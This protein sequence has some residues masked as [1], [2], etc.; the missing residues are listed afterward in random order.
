MNDTESIRDIRRRAC[1]ERYDHGK[2]RRKAV[3][4]ETLA[5]YLPPRRDP[6]ALLDESNKG[7]LASLIPIRYERMS[8]SDF[9]F[10]RGAA[11]VMAHDLAAQTTPGLTVQ[12]SGDCH[13]MNFGAFASPEGN[14]L[15]DIN[16]F[17][18]TLPDVDFTVDLRRLST[19]FAVAARAASYSEKNCRRIAEAVATAYRRHMA[20][21]SGLSPLEA[22]N[23]RIYM[24]RET[25]G[26]FDGRLAEKLRAAIAKTNPDH[27]E[28]ENF[29]H[30]E[31]K[32]GAWRILDRP[33][34][35]Y[36]VEDS[37]DPAARLDIAGVFGA[38][39]ST[40]PPEVLA[41]LQR[42][43]LRD[44][45]FKVVGVG[46]VGTYC[47]I[48][49][50]VTEDGDPLYLQLKEARASALERLGRPNWSGMQ[51]ARV[52]A[53]Q[54]VLQGAS[55]LFLGWTHDAASGRH[56]YVRHLKNR[57]L[58]SITEL[59]EEEALPQYAKLCGHTLARAH[60]RSADP[61]VLSGYMGKSGA[62]DDAIASFAMLYADQN[63]ADFESFVDRAATP[64]P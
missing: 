35:I 57:R 37:P 53:G 48:G 43:R 13:L 21:L 12:A 20:D 24:N 9:A 22:W 58:G 3:P 40:L 11:D 23:S 6:V 2:R 49:L 14:A 8:Q 42:Y 52:V 34:L 39:Q 32:H 47:A 50:Y 26:L 31:K 54:R 55:D 30:V 16:D 62:F 59:L 51:G 56:F 38:C 28:D 44:T 41:L 46:S 15:F 18:E 60:A 27:D 64:T 63:R 7:R 29:P 45:A 5:E 17:D 1:R 19:S 25:D 4:R 61:A 10:L 36:H 33:P